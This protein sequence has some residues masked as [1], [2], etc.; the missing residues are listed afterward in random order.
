MADPTSH[1]NIAQ[2][3]YQK[4]VDLVNANKTLELIHELDEIMINSQAV[5]EVAQKF[6]DT[7]CA[8]LG[9]VDGLVVEADEK[10]EYLRLIG[11]TQTQVNKTVLD[12]AGTAISDVRFGLA[13][14]GNELVE[15]FNSKSA[16][17][18]K[19]EAGLWYPL[20]GADEVKDVTGF[21]DGA[22]LIYPIVMRGKVLGCYAV[23]APAGVETLTEFERIVL[24][25]LG[26]VFGLAIDRMRVSSELRESQEREL[27]HAR[28]LLKLK[29]EFVFIATH[30]LRTPVTAISGFLELIAHSGE[31]Y[32]ADTQENLNAIIESSHRLEKLVEDLLEVARSESGTMQLEV[33]PVDIGQV[34]DKVIGE[35]KLKA[36]EKGVKF[37]TTGEAGTV[38][39]D[40]GKLAE[41][42][43]NLLSNAVKFNRPDGKVTVG[44][45]RLDKLLEVR[46]A[47]TG[48]GISEKEQAKVFTKFFKTRTEDTKRVPGTGLGLFVVRMLVE[49][50]GGQIKFES[51]EGEGTTFTFTLPLVE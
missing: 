34:M 45:T 14:S 9:F 25:R 19:G 48:F 26:T 41:V 33:K 13:G 12:L 31:Q 23:S 38:A 39:A 7:I 8:K 20:V 11:V 43:E 44:Y 15:V 16:K 50:M 24:T 27:G 6:I 17:I 46:I 10:S 35:V 49:K 32:S 18:V 3:L 1:P 37:E 29:D 28:E 47:D 30:D 5:E 40:E 22:V 2:E 4:N 51:K 42:L 21:N 36:E